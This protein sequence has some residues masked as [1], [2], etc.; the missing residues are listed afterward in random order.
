MTSDNN[1][2]N[3]ESFPYSSSIHDVSNVQQL[4]SL[5]NHFQFQT[6]SQFTGNSIT[7]ERMQTNIQQLQSS[8]SENCVLNTDNEADED[9]VSKADS[10]T[11]YL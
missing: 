9:N 6:F 2:S 5:P 11:C 10:N 4:I 8:H 7:P 3:T 1:D